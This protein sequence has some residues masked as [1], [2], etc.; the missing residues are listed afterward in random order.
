MLAI[1]QDQNAS[2]F[3][4]FIDRVLPEANLTTE[5]TTFA[6][7]EPAMFGDPTQYLSG[8]YPADAVFRE[9]NSLH[10]VAVYCTDFAGK[11]Y[12]EGSLE[13]SPTS[14]DGDWFKIQLTSFFT[15]HEFGNVPIPECTFTGVEGFNFTG[16]IRW[17]RFRYIPD[18]DNTGTLDKILYRN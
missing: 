3:F 8:A 4:E 9:D 7:I 13:E 10:T 17:V 15:Y 11:L 12:I 1:D 2:G 18:D 14:S 5:I 6:E 16:S